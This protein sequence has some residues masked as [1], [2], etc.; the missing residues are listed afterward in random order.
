MTRI[1]HSPHPLLLAPC[2]PVEKIKP[3]HLRLASRMIELAI[4]GDGVGLAAPQVGRS[5]QLIVV[6]GPDGWQ[7]LFNPVV[8]KRGLETEL[9]EEGCLSLPGVMR[10]V[11][12]AQKVRV[13]V[14][15]PSGESVYIDA[16]GFLARI[17]QHEIDHLHG[18]MIA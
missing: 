8:V 6:K 7:A 5:I 13:D 1:I 9:G 14:V 15:L 10:V 3:Q 16:H 17:L 11:E 12:R 2:R 18:L 4:A